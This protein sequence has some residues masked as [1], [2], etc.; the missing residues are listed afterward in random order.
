M[1]RQIWSYLILTLAFSLAGCDEET[2]TQPAP[3]P[4]NTPPSMSTAAS[5]TWAPIAPMGGFMGFGPAIGVA[6]FSSGRLWPRCLLL[7]AS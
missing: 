6:D 7:F 5:N 2:P 1:F 4:D 3:D